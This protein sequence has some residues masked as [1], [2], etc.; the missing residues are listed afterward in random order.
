MTDSPVAQLRLVLETDDLEAA[1]AFYRDVLGLRELE[2]YDGPG[3]AR[4]AFE[5]PDAA[6]AAMR[7][8]AGGAE[9]VA[10]PVETPWRSLNARF[11]APG[12]M[13]VTVFEELGPA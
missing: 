4:V 3:G 1:L 13:Q 9:V 7:L 8:A 2:A 11:E 5:V 10:P 12:G 6:A